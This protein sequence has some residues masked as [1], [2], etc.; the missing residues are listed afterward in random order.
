[1]A[2]ESNQTEWLDAWTE[3]S[4]HMFDSVVAANRAAVAAFGIDPPGD[5]TA[6]IEPGAEREEWHAETDAETPAE[7]SVG[8]RFAFT[9]TVS[10]ED[11]HRFAVASGDTVVP[12]AALTNRPAATPANA[13]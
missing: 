9:K 12:N 4:S 7:L 5:D 10:D 13:T 1:M 11:V 3:T 2:F 8:D 6:S